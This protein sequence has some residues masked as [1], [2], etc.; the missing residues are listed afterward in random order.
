M[1]AERVDYTPR[2]DAMPEIEAAVLASIYKFVLDTAKQKAAAHTPDN[3]PDDA[4]ESNSD[5]AATKNHS[6]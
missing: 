5:C 3:G 4:K 1:S 2:P 6:R